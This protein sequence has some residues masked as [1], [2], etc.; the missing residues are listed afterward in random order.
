M[1]VG[2]DGVVLDKREIGDELDMDKA[3]MRNMGGEGLKRRY[4]RDLYCYAL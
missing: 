4:W 1:G 3:G 2:V